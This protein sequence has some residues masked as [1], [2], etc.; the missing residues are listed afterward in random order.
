LLFYGKAEYEAGE[1]INHLFTWP[2][3]G[4]K[5]FTVILTVTDNLGVTDT[6]SKKI[7]VTEF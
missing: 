6:I 7:S 1:E 4:D 2:E 5:E 3:A